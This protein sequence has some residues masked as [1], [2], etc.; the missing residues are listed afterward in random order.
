MEPWNS[1]D[2]ARSPLLQRVFVDLDVHSRCTLKLMGRSEGPSEV[3]CS[4]QAPL[5][6]A[7]SWR[8]ARPTCGFRCPRRSLGAKSQDPSSSTIWPIH[9]CNANERKPFCDAKRPR[10]GHAEVTSLREKK[11]LAD[12]T[13]VESSFQQKKELEYTVIPKSLVHFF[14]FGVHIHVFAILLQQ[15]E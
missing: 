2:L 8:L 1:V 13:I 7:G 15:H 3:D 5:L 9:C 10:Q 6:L 12:K 4:V 14:Q 11:G